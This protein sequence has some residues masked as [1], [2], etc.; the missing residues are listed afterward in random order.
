MDLTSLAGTLLKL[1]GTVIGTALGGPLG[2]T[3]AT[4]VIAE[5]AKQFDTVA[6]PEAIEAAIAADPEAATKIQAVES[7]RSADVLAIFNAEITDKHDARAT[8]VEM[9]RQDSLLAWSPAIYS[10]FITLSFV[11]V[12][13]TLLWRPVEIANGTRDILNILLGVLTAELKGVGGYF[14]GSSAGSVRSGEALRTIA[15]N[16]TNPGPAQIAGKVLDAA[17][18]KAVRR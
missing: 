13:F 2:G 1:G 7:A 11:A 17:V 12:V 8:Q 10:A 18:T 15:T 3:V 6:T 9:V 14:L 4:T 5:L 16:A